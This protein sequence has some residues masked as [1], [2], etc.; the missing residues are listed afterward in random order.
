MSVSIR[1][2][3]DRGIEIAELMGKLK[4]EKDEIDARLEKAGLAG[5]QIALEDEEREGRQFLARGTAQVVPVVFTA[6]Q[7]VKSFAAESAVHRQ[8]ATAA[9]GKLA[10]FY[11]E[12]RT[13]HAVF[14]TGKLLR[15]QAAE[16]FGTA[17]PA[18]VTACL[19]RDKFG[20]VK[21]QVRVEWGRA[22]AV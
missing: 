16:I 5:E 8:I 20:V 10:Q 19:A 13:L 22:Q 4:K 12:K 21:S 17:A 7:V 18:F 3:V 14:E 6:D 9:D 2:D 11:A 1:A 15:R